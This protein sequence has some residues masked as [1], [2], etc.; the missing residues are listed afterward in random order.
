M[1]LIELNAYLTQSPTL[2]DLAKTVAM[3]F[4]N[5]NLSPLSGVS[6]Y[7]GK[8]VESDPFTSDYSKFLNLISS[9][10]KR[11]NLDNH[12]ADKSLGG[13][14]QALWFGEENNKFNFERVLLM[15][16][17]YVL[18]SHVPG[19]DEYVDRMMDYDLAKSL[20]LTPGDDGLILLS[21]DMQLKKHGLILLSRNI[22]IY[23]HQFLR[24]YF[25]CNFVNI[26]SL[27]EYCRVKGLQISLLLDP[28]RISQPKYYRDI[29]EADYWHGPLFSPGLLLNKHLNERTVHFSRGLTD[30]KYDAA[31]TVF[32]T[33]MMDRYL[34]EFMVEEYCPLTIQYGKTPE[35]LPG[36]GNKYCIQKFAHFV[37][38]QQKKC[39]THLDGAV[40]VF[41]PDEYEVYFN[42]I[43]GGKGV[44]EKIGER[45]KLFLLEGEFNEELAKDLLTEWFRYN[46]HIQEYFSGTTIEPLIT[47]VR[48]AELAT[49]SR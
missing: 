36:T 16:A 27:L 49:R 17:S 5:R 34:R 30:A 39:F 18:D 15:V 25:S 29:I 47:Y 42:T 10:L 45:H 32:R 28:I 13:L 20:G 35:K 48:M 11:T 24:R 9:A 7:S 6:T 19:I 40:R 3:E 38:D 2:Q 33:K 23:P 26:L 43:K 4:H 46:P 1:D 8:V 21:P 31:F 12:S 44:D 22:L 41:S 37:Y 14:R